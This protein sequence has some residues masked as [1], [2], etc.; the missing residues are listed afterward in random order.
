[1]L[2]VTGL[3]VWTFGVELAWGLE[4]LCRLP[5]LAPWWAVQ[6]NL[7]AVVTT[8]GGILVML[9]TAYR[10]TGLL[11]QVF[12]NNGYLVF[13]TTVAVNSVLAVLFLGLRR[14]P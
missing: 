3:L 13:V 11:A 2:V 8:G 9:V 1:M 10:L 7:P 6:R 5:I 12:D 14:T 4:G